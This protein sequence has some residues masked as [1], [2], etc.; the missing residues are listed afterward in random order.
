MRSAALLALLVAGCG[1]STGGQNAGIG[2]NELARLSTPEVE[3]EVDAQLAARPQPLAG[4]DLQREGMPNPVCDF[5]SGGHV[6]LAATAA[7]AIARIDGRLLHFNHS[8][9]L[10]ATGGFLEDRQISISVGRTSETDPETGD[11]GRWAGRI[12]VTN[13][14]ARARV[15]L[16][17]V[18]RCGVG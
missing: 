4:A 6:L 10:G 8:I 11:S 13:R 7:D 12:T 9:P 5:S 14:R 1:G 17:G 18:W 2:T 15:E 16:N 3:P